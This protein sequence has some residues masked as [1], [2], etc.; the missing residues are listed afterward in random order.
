LRRL[1]VPVVFVMLTT[2][3]SA[4]ATG[5][6]QSHSGSGSPSS[7]ATATPAAAT[8]RPGEYT[9]ENAAGA[10]GTLSIPGTPDPEIEKLRAYVGGESVTYLTVRV[11][12][13]KG[14]EAVNM[15]GVSIFTRD[16]QELKYENAD[17]YLED[18]RPSNAPAELYN[19][20]V[21]LGNQHMPTSKP[22]TVKDFVLVGP[23]VPEAFSKVSVYAAG[24]SDPAN[25]LPAG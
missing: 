24:T 1:L 23:A 14:T 8:M 9:F 3:C 21:K 22:A 25:A 12:N 5:G 10:V 2:G 19:S 4:T 17:A 15:H 6:H 18:L 11:D 20:F 16:G 7:T 13:R